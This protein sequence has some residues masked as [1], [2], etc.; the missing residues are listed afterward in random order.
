VQHIWIQK[1]NYFDVND[2]ASHLVCEL[3][4]QVV[5]PADCSGHIVAEELETSIDRYLN[6]FEHT[7]GRKRAK[8]RFKGACYWM[9]WLLVRCAT[10]PDIS[11]EDV[12]E[13]QIGWR[14]FTDEIIQILHE[15]T[16]EA[17]G[18][19]KYPKYEPQI[20][21]ALDRTKERLHFYFDE[22]HDDPLFPIFKRPLSSYAEER[23]FRRVKE[24]SIRINRLKRPRKRMVPEEEFYTDVIENYFREIPKKVVFWMVTYGTMRECMKPIYWGGMGHIASS[25][26]EG[27][28]PIEMYLEPLKVE[29]EY[30]QI[31]R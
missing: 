4:R 11:R 16:R 23:V 13:I 28:W 1:V 10:R 6:Q 5:E 17:I 12:E 30:S 26:G 29:E 14:T 27:I 3:F 25:S 18:S 2:E 31:G 21:Q 22:L 8:K 15:K 20:K 7:F 9:A 19:E 24:D